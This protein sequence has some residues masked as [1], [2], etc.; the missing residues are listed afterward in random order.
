MS[1][2]SL[3]EQLKHPNPN[4]QQRAMVELS[5]I[6]DES[7][8]PRLMTI[9][10]DEDIAY[11]RTAVKALGYIGVEAVPTLVDSLINSDS[12]V[13]RASCAKALAQVSYNHPDEHF[14]EEGLNG[15][16]KAL[17]DTDAVVTIS[18]VMCLGQIGLPALDILLETLKT[19]D[20]PALGVGIVNAIGGIPDP[21]CK[22]TLTALANDETADSYVRESAVSALGRLDMVLKYKFRS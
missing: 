2:D 22:E 17:Q 18:T 11:R 14:P 16:Q 20:N 13:V 12:P 8:I 19:T 7:I 5:E 10:G 21:R 9:V 1:I 6:K 3:F 15:L 4:L